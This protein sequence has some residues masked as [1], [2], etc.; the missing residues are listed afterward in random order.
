MLRGK[1]TPISLTETD[2][3]ETSLAIFGQGSFDLPS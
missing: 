2:A 3:K 1:I